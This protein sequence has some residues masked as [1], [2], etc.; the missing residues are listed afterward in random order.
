MW[1]YRVSQTEQLS[2]VVRIMHCCIKAETQQSP[3]YQSDVAKSAGAY[4]GSPEL[5]R[6]E[7]SL[8]GILAD[9]TLDCCLSLCCGCSQNAHRT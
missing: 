6:V 8:L 4:A 9:D 5:I 3:L 7:A 1:T 2:C